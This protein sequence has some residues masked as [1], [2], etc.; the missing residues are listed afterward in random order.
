VAANVL[1]DG[2]ENDGQRQPQQCK[3]GNQQSPAY[4]FQHF[5]MSSDAAGRVRE[6]RTKQK[7]RQ[8]GGTHHRS[9][10][11]KAMCRGYTLKQYQV[12]FPDT[13]KSNGFVRNSYTIPATPAAPGRQQM[14]RCGD[15]WSMKLVKARA[16]CD[17]RLEMGASLP[18]RR[19]LAI[20]RHPTDPSRFH[21]WRLTKF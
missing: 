15:R 5:H 4:G 3:S 17:S 16:R 8:A 19:G 6:G 1:A 10:R 11:A 7:T 20:T 18:D 12:S 2:S 14:S 9:L 13:S 21:A